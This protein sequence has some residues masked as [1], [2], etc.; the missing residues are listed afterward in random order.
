MF[1]I[2]VIV[3][4]RAEQ[5]Y[6]SKMQKFAQ[7]TLSQKD[8]IFLDF[9]LYMTNFSGLKLSMKELSSLCIIYEEYKNNFFNL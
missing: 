6:S 4:I 3:F 5:N 7:I 9:M 8:G 1:F 2:H